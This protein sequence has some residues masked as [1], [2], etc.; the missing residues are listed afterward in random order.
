ME[1]LN[2]NLKV[3]KEYNEA[4]LGEL[5]IITIAI[6]AVIFI[7]Y[8]WFLFEKFIQLLSFVIVKFFNGEVRVVDTRLLSESCLQEDKREFEKISET[9]KIDLFADVTPTTHNENKIKIDLW[10]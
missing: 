10:N 7:Y 2:L 9:N 4:Y 8:R 6:W 5:A 3:I 1:N